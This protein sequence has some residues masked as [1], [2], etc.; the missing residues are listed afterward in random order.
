MNNSNYRLK[1]VGSLIQKDVEFMRD[2]NSEANQF[3]QKWN[4]FSLEIS[5]NGYSED[6]ENWLSE[7]KTQVTNLYNDLKTANLL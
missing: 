1:V 6:W 3:I 7:N 5:E 4:E 2:F